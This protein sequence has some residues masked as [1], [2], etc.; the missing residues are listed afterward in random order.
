VV[1]AQNYMFYR[2]VYLVPFQV[3]AA[4]GVFWLF[5][6]SDKILFFRGGRMFWILKILI[7]VLVVLFF[8][9]YALRSVD[10]APLH[11]LTR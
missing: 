7:L 10:G 5:S 3:L 1:S 6:Y 4:I 2:I 9:N 8:F 11:M